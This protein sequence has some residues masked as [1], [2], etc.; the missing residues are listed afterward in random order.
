MS[1]GLNEGLKVAFSSEFL[2]FFLQY[3]LQSLPPHGQNLGPYSV[4]SSFFPIL[5]FKR[6]SCSFFKCSWYRVSSSE[7]RGQSVW[8]E[9]EIGA[10]LSLLSVCLNEQFLSSA[11][12]TLIQSFFAETN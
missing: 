4:S 8:N 1:E 5:Y 11:L 7:S 9:G 6:I 2:N 3:K 12:G 10:R